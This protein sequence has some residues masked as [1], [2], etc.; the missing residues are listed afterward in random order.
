MYIATEMFLTR[1]L[2]DALFSIFSPVR[3]FPQQKKLLR[4][5]EFHSVLS[6]N[7][8]LTERR[9]SASRP[10]HEAEVDDIFGT[11]DALDAQN[12]LHS[13]FFT[14]TNLLKVPKYGPEEINIAV[15]VDRQVATE[16][17]ITKLADD[18][19]QLKVE[20]LDTSTK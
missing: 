16:S 15:V 13:H 14:V 11:F 20:L 17:C 8:M 19:D 6:S 2:S 7:E 4:Q 3:T 5:Q 9:C 12:V 1:M 18:L 10:A